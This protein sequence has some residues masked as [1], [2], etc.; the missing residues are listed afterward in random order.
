M[1]VILTATWRKAPAAKN[2]LKK[3]AASESAVHTKGQDRMD[4]IEVP[5]DTALLQWAA[6]RTP[7]TI[8][9]AGSISLAFRPVPVRCWPMALA[10]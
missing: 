9:E 5:T 7:G 2:S 10:R 1:P 6:S 4:G 8:G 3:S